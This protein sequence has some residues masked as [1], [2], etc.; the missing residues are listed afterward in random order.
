MN[1]S[2]I[3]KHLGISGDPPSLA[4]ARIPDEPAYDR[5]GIRA[6]GLPPSNRHSGTKADHR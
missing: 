4:S 6:H 5:Q 2:K 3:P 1:H